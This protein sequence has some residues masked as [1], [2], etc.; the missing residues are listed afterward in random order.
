MN[1]INPTV[2]TEFDEASWASSGVNWARSLK[3]LM[4]PGVAVDY[5]IP[6]E[7]KDKLK[8]LGLVCLPGQTELDNRAIDRY[9]SLLVGDLPSGVWLFC[10][11]SHP[12]TTDTRN[13]FALAGS[14][15]VCRTQPQQTF[16][17]VFPV[18]TIENRVKVSTLIEEGVVKKYGDPLNASWLCGPTAQWE[19]FIGFCKYC[20][21]AGLVERRAVGLENLLLNLFAVS[22]EGTTEVI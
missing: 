1:D 8:E 11:P 20:L 7:G 19:T 14:K 16:Y 22:F 3:T 10:P 9:A 6:P 13:L 5:G 18:I 17:M 15:L 12:L 2:I 21:G 4:L